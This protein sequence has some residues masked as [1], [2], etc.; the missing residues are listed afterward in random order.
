MSSIDNYE[1]LNRR[2]FENTFSIYRRRSIVFVGNGP[3]E[4]ADKEIVERADTVVR[5]NNWGSRSGIMHNVSRRCDMVFLNGDCHTTN[6]NK[7][8]VGDPLMAVMAISYPH[9]AQDG[10]RLLTRFYKNSVLAQIN[11]FWLRDLCRM[12]GYKS[13]GT[14]HP[15]PTVGLT[16]MYM[17]SK[18]APEARFHVCGFSWHYDA[19][20]GKV[21][22]HDPDILPS[23]FNHW[24]MRELVF[25][26]H[27]FP[28]W[29]FGRIPQ[30]AINFVKGKTFTWEQSWP[31][32][33]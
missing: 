27:T 28:H 15:L 21:Q 25:V 16:G 30:Q 13:D 29:A 6:I 11:P 12:L 10:D 14:K 23:H 22:G 4:E 2:V 32:A 5:F 24:Y 18:L 31:L 17:L 3:T 8:D 33:L 1:I 19:E 9:H 20:T 7:D 26:A